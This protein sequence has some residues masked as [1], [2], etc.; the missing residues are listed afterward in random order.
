MT[1][2]NGA[3]YGASEDPGYQQFVGWQT[4]ATGQGL[5]GTGVVPAFILSQGATNLP[6]YVDPKANNTQ[7]LGA[8]GGGLLTQV[9]LP[10]DPNVLF[11]NLQIE[12]ELP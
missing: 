3:G 10:R 8:A 11:W 7:L 9:K 1:M 2:L 12:R 6:P 5:T 4:D